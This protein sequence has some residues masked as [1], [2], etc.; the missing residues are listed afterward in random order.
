[1]SHKNKKS[2]VRQVQEAYD[3]MLS[4]GRSKHYDKINGCT[5]EYIYSWSTYK[6]YLK[7]ANYFA[8]YCKKNHNCKTL[9][10]CRPYV[11]EYLRYRMDKELSPYTIK[12]DAA[13][14]AKLYGCS[15]RDFIVTPTRKRS[16]ITRSR[17][18]KVRDNHFAEK[19][20]MELVEFCKSTGL[21]RREL[22]LL[23]GEKLINKDGRYYIIVDRG[24]KGG[25]YRE[26]PVIGNIENVVRLMQKSGKEKVFNTIP[27]AADIHGYRAVYATDVYKM[28]ARDIMDIPYDAYNRGTGRYY[29]SGVYSCRGDRKGIKLDK[30]AMMEASKA[31]GHSRISV[32]GE[33]YI[34]I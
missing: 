32:V 33:H 15:T 6:N 13:A 24:A 14:L 21:R 26:A 25:R 16:G 4:I 11:D 23:T 20:H 31:L 30:L 3:S 10:E 12:L 28:Y 8:K 18:K 17:G 7:Q 19:N 2:L 9:D 1:M 27:G 5:R 22:E 34:N 29:Q